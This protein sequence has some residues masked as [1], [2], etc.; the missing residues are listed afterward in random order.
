M[1]IKC[2]YP[3]CSKQATFKCDC[4]NNSNNCYL[5]MQDHKMQKD[6]FIRPVKSKSLAAKVEDNQ[7]ALNY[8]TY[9]S[10]N[11]AQKMINEVKSCLIKN[12]NLIKNEKQRI[13]TLTLSKSESQ[14]KT[15]LNWASSLKNIKR[16]SKAYTKCLKML[17]GIDKDSIKLIEEAKKQEILNQRVEENLK[18]NIEKNNDLAKKLAETE[19]K[20]K[21]SELCIKTVDMKLE[22]LRI[23]FPSSRFESK[24]Q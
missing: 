18:K 21:C 3:N 9:N 10:I 5:H 7:N 23:I 14:V 24:F 12:L 13:K 20:L 17:L 11:L 6:C 22:E 8:L 16:D 19:E 15:I 2:S 1:D 4:S